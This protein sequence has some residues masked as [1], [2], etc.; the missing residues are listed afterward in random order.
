MVREVARS[1]HLQEQVDEIG[2]GFA[3]IQRVIERGQAEGVFRADLDPRLASW[4]FYGGLE[5]ILTGWVLGQLPDGDEEV[6]RAERTIVDVVCGG[7]A[8]RR[9][10]RLTR[11]APRHVVKLGVGRVR[12]RVVA[13]DDR[14]VP[15]ADPR[16]VHRL[17]DADRGRARGRG[18]LRADAAARDRPVERHVPHAARPPAPVHARRGRPDRLLPRADRV[19]AEPLDDGAAR[20]SRFF[21]AYYVYEPPYRGLYPD[22]LPERVFGRAQG[23]Q[24]L[25]RGHRARR[26]ADRRRLPLPP[27]AAGAVPRRRGVVTAAC[28]VPVLFVREDGGHGRVFEGVGTYVRH[29]WRVLRRNPD[30]GRFLLANAAW[31][32]TFAGARTFVVLYITVG[33]GEP[34]STST[35]VLAAVAG[36]YVVAALVAGPVGDRFGLARVITWCSVVYGARAARRRPRD[37]S[38][39]PGTSP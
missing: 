37:A 21:F 33:L 9:R 2:M 17:D 39:T 8:V 31:E 5:E 28:L 10:R 29:S 7:L 15:A 34:L 25:F 12:P 13:D 6:A 4:I 32:G 14:R 20:S 3:A 19:H 38:G 36:G 1:S 27:L 35:L 18:R 11:R 30:V 24:H 16:P 23:V 26:R 22:L